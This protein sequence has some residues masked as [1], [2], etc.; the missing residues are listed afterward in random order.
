MAIGSSMKGLVALLVVVIVMSSSSFE[1]SASTYNVG[2]KNGG[3]VVNPKENY[4]LWSQRY[5]FRVND[6]LYFK[7][8]RGK[9][10]VLIVSIEDYD[11][12]NTAKPLHRFRGGRSGSTVQL[13][14]PGPFY[15]I[16]GNQQNCQKGQKFAVNVVSAANPPSPTPHPSPAPSPPH[17]SPAPSSPPPH[18]PPS[19]GMP[20]S[21]ADLSPVHA[22]APGPA[23]NG[24]SS[25]SFGVG[26]GVISLV[27]ALLSF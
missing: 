25:R 5:T 3:W 27:V 11:S 2:G 4:T 26:F 1:A 23:R 18:H 19:G 9:D 24:G 17:P 8:E 6:Y 20:A 13:N 15:F 16:S 21:P 22:P 7:Y 14:K 10:S 12:C